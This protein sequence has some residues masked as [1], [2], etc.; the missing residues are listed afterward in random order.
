MVTMQIAREPNEKGFDLV[1]I[2][3]PHFLHSPKTANE[4]DNVLEMTP[5]GMP[6]V[7]AGR[8]DLRQFANFGNETID[9]AFSS[10]CFTTPLGG[11][12]APFH[13]RPSGPA[14]PVEW[15]GVSFNVDAR[16]E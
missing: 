10:E 3:R 9:G 15:A 13:K 16:R 11:E 12:V 6:R 5:H 7:G 1:M 14:Q 2:A 4:I 8:G